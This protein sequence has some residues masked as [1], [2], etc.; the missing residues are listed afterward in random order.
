M[1]RWQWATL[2]QLAGLLLTLVLIVNYGRA[3]SWPVPGE[4]RRV[5]LQVIP[6]QAG[7][8]PNQVE[9]TA[10]GGV[11]RKARADIPV[12]EAKLKV[13]KAGRSGG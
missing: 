12:R 7:T 4:T 9:A 13:N 11:L 8:F 5:G 10:A 2:A 3:R 1:K 6:T